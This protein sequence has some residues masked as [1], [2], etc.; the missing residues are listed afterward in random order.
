LDWTR[1][2][3]VLTPSIIFQRESQHAN[4]YGEQRKSVS[5]PQ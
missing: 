5:S 1:V 2:L 3:F 4:T